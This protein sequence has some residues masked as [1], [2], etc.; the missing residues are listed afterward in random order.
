MAGIKKP[1]PRAIGGHSPVLTPS[2]RKVSS[3]SQKVRPVS[4][5]AASSY[6]LRLPEAGRLSGL[7]RFR[8]AYSCGAAL[9]LHQLP[10]SQVWRV[11]PRLSAYEVNY[12]YTTEPLVACQYGMDSQA[13]TICATIS[14]LEIQAGLPNESTTKKLRRGEKSAV[15]TARAIWSSGPCGNFTKAAIRDPRSPG[16][17]SKGTAVQ[18]A[19]LASQTGV[20]QHR[21]VAYGGSS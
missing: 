17:S 6:S 7:R 14:A 12:I 5:L 11:S 13:W 10:Y 9:A 19:P 16:Y 1:Q 4:W 8:S 15:P 3:V 18:T 21:D 2:P 20:R